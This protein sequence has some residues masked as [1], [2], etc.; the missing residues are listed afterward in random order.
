MYQWSELSKNFPASSIRK[1]AKL[2]SEFDDTLMLTIGEPNF[3][4][5]E[6]IKKAGQDAIAANRTHYGPNVGEAD[7]QKA[8]AVKYTDQTG[9]PFQ[10]NEVMAT[11]GGTEGILHIMM[12]V[13]NTGDEVIIADPSYPNYLG[14][15][16]MLGA[17]V[18]PVP[19]YE[20]N[21]F[22]MQAADIEK[23]ITSK[24][25]LI[26]LNT[27]NNPLGSILD[28]KDIE[29]IVALAD[30]HQITILSDEVYES[31][32]YDGN[33][34]FSLFQVPGAKENHFV[35]NSLSKTYAMTGWRIGYVVGNPQAIERMA[36]FREAIGFCVP[37]FIQEA[38]VAAITSSQA[39]VHYF[40]SEYDK[41][42]HIIVEG[43]N[44]I[45]GF[46]CLKTEGA[47]YA[48]PNI[49]A[50]GKSSYDFAMEI[51]TETHVALTPGSA[52]G[53]MGEGYLRISFAESEEVLQ[54]AV[55]RI[56]TYI[57]KA[58]PHLG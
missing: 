16:M 52:F 11:F 14:Q 38:A 49:K 44:K 2:A 9:I 18:V 23:A 5:P 34:H 24:T 1:M 26:I 17:T 42:R 4:T 29:D 50:F 30:R 48:F 32:I 13:L 19:V 21:E 56:A 41:R 55:D 22:K 53:K 7:F 57:K 39:E 6:F 37:P 35:V 36:E 33:K 28:Q 54:E 51:L 12:T 31:L 46:N 27:P 25:K 45:P 47:F 8:V 43:L 3:E 20:H 15:I 58:Y 10:P 40:L